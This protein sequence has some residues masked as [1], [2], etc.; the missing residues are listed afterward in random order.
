MREPSMKFPVICPECA[1]ESIGEFQIAVIATAL[2]TGK[3]LRLYSDC[4]DI[5]WTATR[6]EREQLR[7]YL[8]AIS[9]DAREL[10]KQP[11]EPSDFGNIRPSAG[12]G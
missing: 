6:V 11:Q 2:M 4:H 12:S 8:A 7:E 1:R 9:M 3:S 10:D 5:Y